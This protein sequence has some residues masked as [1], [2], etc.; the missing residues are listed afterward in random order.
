MSVCYYYRLSIGDDAGSGSLVSVVVGVRVSVEAG[1]SEVL[2]GWRLRVDGGEVAVA[3]V[4]AAATIV[5]GS[6][7]AAGAE[8]LVDEVVAAA[9]NSAVGAAVAFAVP[10]GMK[11]GYGVDAVADA[12]V[13]VGML[14]A[15]VVVADGSGMYAVDADSDVEAADKAS[16]A[17]APA[18]VVDVAGLATAAVDLVGDAVGLAADTGL[19]V[20]IDGLAIDAAVQAVGTGLVAVAEDN[21]HHQL[22]SAE[23]QAVPGEDTAAGAHID[24][25]E[26]EDIDSAVD[27]D[28]D[29]DLAG[30][31]LAGHSK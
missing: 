18:P 15:V 29:V 21:E 1:G 23:L 16:V 26:P 7:V 31:E 14:A 27:E 20:G 3:A 4:V 13:A 11:P 19:A 22:G 30:D 10:V 17:V 5:G 28:T 9:G 6:H 2:R 8:G 24:Q 12:H 25:P